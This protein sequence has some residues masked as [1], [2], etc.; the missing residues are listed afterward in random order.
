M[1]IAFAREGADIVCSYWKE[2]E[3]AAE[4]RRLVEAAGRRCITVPG[5]IGDREHCRA[6]VERAVGDLGTSAAR[7]SARPGASPCTRGRPEGYT[8]VILH[9]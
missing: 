5:D 7:S 3:D 2:H 8:K 1:A 9:P 6:L 4:T